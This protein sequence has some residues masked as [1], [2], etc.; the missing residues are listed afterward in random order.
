MKKVETKEWKEFLIKDIF[1]TLKHN[2]TVQVPTGASIRKAELEEGSVARISVTNNNNGIVGYFDSY[3]KNYRIFTNF[4]SVSFLSTVFYHPYTASLDMKVHCLKLLNCELN[5]YIA[6]FLISV[7]KKTLSGYS[8]AD[9]ISSKLLPN[10]KIMLPVN[11]Q[12]L[13]DFEYMESYIKK[14]KVKVTDKT[15]KMLRVNRK[16]NL[17]DSSNWGTF[18]LYEIFDIDSGTK[19]DKI[20]MDFEDPEI[21]LIGR[22]NSNQGVAAKVSSKK[23]IEPY[24]AGYL[25]LALGGAYLGSCFVQT[26]PFYT[27]QNVIVL[28]PKYEM[29]DSVK[30][31]ICTSIFVESQLHYKAF[32]DEL[33]RHIKKDFT[34]KLPVNKYNQPDWNYMEEFMQEIFHKKRHAIKILQMI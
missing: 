22:A 13:P 23:D 21:N 3:S 26:E 31:F 33:N 12:N 17:I 1:V 15:N 19:L 29:S 27:S 25:T 9:Q 14:L 18:H 32:I 2:K 20:K 10:L 8:Y 16:F 4:I 11:K 24:K 5:E 28:R 34:I 30:Q 6:A 7:I